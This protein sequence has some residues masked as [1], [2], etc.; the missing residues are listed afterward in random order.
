MKTPFIKIY[1]DKQIILNPLYERKIAIIGYGSQGRAQALNLRDSGF[2]PVIGLRGGSESGRLAKRDGF[3]I[4]NLVRAVAN[5]DVVVILI[6]DHFHNDLFTKQI[7]KAIHPGQTFVFAH[8]LSVHFGL[9][10]QP[11]GVDYV[12]VAPH[13]PGIMMRERYQEGKGVPAFIAT[14]QNSSPRSLKLAAAYGKAIGCGRAGLI[15]TSFADEAV[16]DI[17]GEQAVLCGG[18]AGL[19]KAG[20]ATLIKGGLSPQN[21][22]LECIY[23]LD[24]IIDLIKRYGIGGMYDRISFTAEYG[25]RLAENKII[26]A[27]SKRAMAGLLKQIKSGQFAAELMNSSKHLPKQKTRGTSN[28]YESQLDRLAIYMD[29]AFGH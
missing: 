19:L 27:G 21:A 15:I 7:A 12:L 10:E 14:A 6:P 1:R 5:S 20:F 29:K 25:G 26:N 18:L 24:L 28:K 23:Q 13:A 11:A 2:T 3:E 17:F 16:G 9:I 8:S 4:T 22:Y